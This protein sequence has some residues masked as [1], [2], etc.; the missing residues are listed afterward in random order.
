MKTKNKTISVLAIV[1]AGLIASTI[2]SQLRENDD[3]LFSLNVEALANSEQ[4]RCT[5]PKE[6]NFYTGDYYCKSENLYPCTDLVSG[7]F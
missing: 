2:Y 5:G 7:C 1:G 6:Y 3:A 4:P